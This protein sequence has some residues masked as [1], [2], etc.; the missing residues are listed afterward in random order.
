MDE[1]VLTTTSLVPTPDVLPLAILYSRLE[2]IFRTFHVVHFAASLYP[3]LAGASSKPT[4]RRRSSVL[5]SGSP[6]YNVLFRS[7]RRTLV[8][9]FTSGM[10]LQISS[11]VVSKT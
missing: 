5:W 2:P 3:I 1:F 8:L 7:I 11:C 6:E 4:S 10:Q 9:T